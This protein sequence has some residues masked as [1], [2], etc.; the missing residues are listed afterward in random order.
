MEGRISLVHNGT[1]NNTPEL[2][3]EL[4]AKGVVFKSET[5]TEV[6]ALHNNTCLDLCYHFFPVLALQ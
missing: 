6:I 1:I 5:D 4:T 3:K 2:K